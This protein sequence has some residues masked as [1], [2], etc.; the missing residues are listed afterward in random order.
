MN[1]G[2]LLTVEQILPEMKSTE[3]WSAIVELGNSWFQAGQDSGPE[4]KETVLE[5]PAGPGG[6]HE[7]RASGSASPSRMPPRPGQ[8]RGRGLRPFL[9]QGIEFESLDNAPVRFIVLFVVPKDQFQTHLRTL[10]AIAKFLNDRSVRESLGNGPD[11]GGDPPD[12]QE[13]VADGDHSRGASRAAARTALAGMEPMG[14]IGPMVT[15][16]TDSRFGDYQTNVAMLLAKGAAGESA[17]GCAANHRRP[18]RHRDLRAPRDRRRR[19]HQFP[20]RTGASPGAALRGRRGPDA[21]GPAGGESADCRHRFLEPQCGEA[22]ARGAYPQHHPRGYA[23]P[24]SR[25]SSDI[26]SSRTITSAIGERSS[27]RS[28]TAGNIGATTRRS[29]AP[30]SRSWCA[31]TRK[32]TRSRRPTRRCLRECREELVKLQQGDPGNVAIWRECVALSWQEFEQMYALLDI[33]FDEHLGE[34]AYNDR[35]APLVQRLLD[36]GIAEISEGAPS[37]FSSATIRRSR[38]SRA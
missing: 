23:G 38:T 19:L 21:R 6:D 28:S 27:A 2:D 8:E 3:R 33:H 36:Q 30:P 13:A 9:G 37:A 20:D 34:S 4:D 11:G 31:F 12:F 14:P 29:G 35:L 10:A 25:V 22:D 18:R 32:P 1:L 5:R 17:P 24:R 7:H 16:A 15:S 26:A